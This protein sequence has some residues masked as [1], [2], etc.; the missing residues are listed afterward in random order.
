MATEQEIYKI[1]QKVEGEE[2]VKELAA[3][4]AKVEQKL[5]DVIAIQ[6]ASS[7]GAKHFAGEMASLSA[8]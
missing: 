7:V 8:N 5:R 2:K 6:G 4:L 3:E 1:I